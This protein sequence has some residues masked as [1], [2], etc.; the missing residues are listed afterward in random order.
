MRTAIGPVVHH[1]SPHA[2]LE[3]LDF[4]PAGTAR[5]ADDSIAR[6][7]AHARQPL[8]LDVTRRTTHTANHHADIADACRLGS[9]GHE[10]CSAQ[11]GRITHHRF[12]RTLMD[13][14][15]QMTD[16][17]GTSMAGKNQQ[18]GTTTKKLEQVTS[19]IPSATWLVLGCGAIVG[20]IVLKAMGRHASANFVGQWVPTILMLGVYNKMVKLMGS[21][22]KTD[23]ARASV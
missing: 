14:M 9:P 19:A 20:S 11:V 3:Q 12:R 21:D 10:E 15:N 13:T 18:E 23:G 5:P 2:E 8:E 16:K 1:D 4:Q 22:R 7:S 17:L 6:G